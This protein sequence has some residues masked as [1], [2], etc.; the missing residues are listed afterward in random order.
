M[1][2]KQK[3]RIVEAKQRHSDIRK[4]ISRLDKKIEERINFYV[5]QIEKTYQN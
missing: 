1:K 2:T 4:V 3:S 5:S